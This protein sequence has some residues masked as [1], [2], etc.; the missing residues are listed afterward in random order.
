MNG[1]KY[2]IDSFLWV[3]SPS[4]KPSPNPSVYKKIKKHIVWIPKNVVPTKAWRI[5]PLSG[6]TMGKSLRELSEPNKKK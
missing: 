6:K 4:S 5:H 2:G 3:C 1:H